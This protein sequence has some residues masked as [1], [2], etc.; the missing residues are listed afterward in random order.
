MKAI[1]GGAHHSVGLTQDGRCIV[2]GRIDGFQTG[3][4][5]SDLASFPASE[6]VFDQSGR[7][8]ILLKATPLPIPPCACVAVGTDHSIAVTQTGKVYSWGMNASAQCGH[9]TEDDILEAKLIEAQTV[10]DKVVVFAVAG[11]QFSMIGVAAMP[12]RDQVL[13]INGA[14]QP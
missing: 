7:P 4:P 3:L 5:V 14:R 6:V 9:G 11:A 13:T 12:Q 8:R 1:P 10:E 2:W